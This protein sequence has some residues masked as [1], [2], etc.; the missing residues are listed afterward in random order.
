ML[1]VAKCGV[2]DGYNSLRV[3]KKMA[4][5]KTVWVCSSCG[6]DAP[7]WEGRCP[8][9]GE[10]NTMVE[11]HVADVKKTR[12]QGNRIVSR[13][14]PQRVSEIETAELP[15]ITMPSRELNRVLGGGLVP[16]SMVL[17]GGEPG[18]G[19]STLVLQNTLSIKSRKVLYVSGE[20][21]A[22]QLRMRA[23]RLGRVSDNVYIVCET[24]LANIFAHIEDVKP[25]LVIIDSIQTIASDDLDSPAGSV[26]Q[27]RECA[28]SLL[29]FA[30][31]SDVPVLLRTYKQGGEHSG[32]E[33]A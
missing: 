18:I 20:E 2:G 8:Q 12:S 11:E 33:S 23:D 10:W 21:S 27:V 32:S 9:C 28:A 6:A 3:Q 1:G 13:T 7:K 14:R 22:T 4:K 15:R 17:I 31:E 26:S 25:G 16:G 29:R 19:K 5:L 24:S 30:K